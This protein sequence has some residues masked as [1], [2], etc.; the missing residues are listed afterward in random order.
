[1]QNNIIK[2]KI[3][4]LTATLQSLTLQ[5]MNALRVGNRKEADAIESVQV[6]IDNKIVQLERAIRLIRS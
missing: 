2:E 3:S 1:M 5:K 6:D 4:S